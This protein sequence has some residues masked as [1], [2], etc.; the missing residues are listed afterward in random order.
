MSFWFIRT[1]AGNVDFAV[2]GLHVT[3]EFS[4]IGLAPVQQNYQ[5]YALQPG[6]R[7]QSTK[8]E[9]RVMALTIDL[10]GS[11]YANMHALRNALVKI[12]APLLPNTTTPVTIV[13]T[14]AARPVHAAFVYLDGLGW[15]S[16]K[17]FGQNIPLQLLAVDPYW[18]E[19]GY[20]TFTLGGQVDLSVNYVVARIGG[21]WQ[22]L[23]TGFN[24]IVQD[25]A[26]DASRGRVYFSG[27]FTTGDG[28]T[29]N[30]IGYWDTADQQFHEM[31]GGLA[32]QGYTLAVAPNGD[33]WVSCGGDGLR[34]YNL[35]TD[36]WTD[37]GDPGS[38]H[39]IT[40][41]E[42]GLNGK[43]YIS[44]DFMNWQGIA[45]ADQVAMYDGAWHALGTSPFTTTRYPQVIA[46]APSGEVYFGELNSST[47]ANLRKWDGATWVTVATTGATASISALK[48]DEAGN[49]YIGG[50]FTQLGGVAANYIAMY[51]HAV[52]TPLG[53]GLPEVTSFITLNGGLLYAGQSAGENLMRWNGSAWHELA[54]TAVGGT[55]RRFVFLGSDLYIG[56]SF[57]G[58]VTVPAADSFTPLSTAPV[59]P[60]IVFSLPA[61]TAALYSITNET[62]NH[63]L[64]LDYTLQAGEQL[65]ID[66]TPGKKTIFST[67]AGD[68]PTALLDGSDLANFCIQGSVENVISVASNNADVIATLTFLTMHWSVDG[69]SSGL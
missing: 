69:G 40:T 65:V 50:N 21:V 67:W 43:V 30:Y 10:E 56:L 19:D 2:Y 33:V 32:G 15:N 51:N 34:R 17:A 59:F 52:I 20:E 6:A 35:A 22:T 1:Q 5:S 16:Y 4:G 37:F 9:P 47:P 41:I 57:S 12:F 63:V 24:G 54:L 7:Y 60:V 38:G 58:T 14:G 36:D 39:H 64:L 11:S 29:L 26:V 23:D 49:L 44:G 61:G 25:L 45:D 68:V 55:S 13:Y 53:A 27:S 3:Q 48:F 46:I 66:L 62:T 28:V 18:Y 31:A 42:I 8:V